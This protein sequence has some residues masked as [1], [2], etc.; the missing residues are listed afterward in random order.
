MPRPSLK[1]QRSQQILDAFVTCVAKFGLEGATQERIAA[2]ARVKRTILRHYLGNRDDMIKA[3]VNHVVD[4][5][6]SLTEGLQ[7]KLP[8]NHAIDALLDYL[9]ADDND[10][11]DAHLNLVYQALV[12]AC[13]EYPWARAPL[14]DSMQRF[15]DLIDDLLQQA[16]PNCSEHNRQAVAHGMVGIYL[17]HDALTPLN[18]S[19]S[20]R[21]SSHR[22]T[23]LLLAQLENFDE[24]S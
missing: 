15:I 24:N 5:F 18:P 4:R 14:L 19:D 7:A 20:W 9:F 13:G 23:R 2:E 21:R 16:F 12:A 22:A 17:T 10:G 6:N 3:L 1:Q 11:V 8:V